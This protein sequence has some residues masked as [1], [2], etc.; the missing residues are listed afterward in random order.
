MVRQ[1]REENRKKTKTKST[2]SLLNSRGACC[3]GDI[4]LFDI[5]T[6]WKVKHTFFFFYVS[7]R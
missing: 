4:Y 2:I 7:V 6:Y 5:S 3:F 1:P